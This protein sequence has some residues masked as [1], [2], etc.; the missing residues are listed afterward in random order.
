MPLQNFRTLL[1]PFLIISMMSCK[2]EPKSTSQPN[3]REF[4]MGS[5]S[6]MVYHY[7]FKV[8]TDSNGIVSE[9][10]KDSLNLHLDI[11]SITD[12]SVYI[13]FPK[14]SRDVLNITT[15]SNLEIDGTHVWRS[16]YGR[17]SRTK[18]FDLSYL[19]DSLI[20]IIN[21]TTGP[22]PH[23]GSFTIWMTKN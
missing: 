7:D 2:K 16:M 22:L 8:F 17:S 6:G 4:L 1:V 13:N 20:G 3:P 23:N 10:I 9:V 21:Y 5:Y 12:T 19:N 11:D 15:N 14:L 18:E